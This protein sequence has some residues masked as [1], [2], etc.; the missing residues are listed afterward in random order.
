[1]SLKSDLHLSWCGHKAAKFACQRWHY[2]GTI[3]AG[4]LVKIGV[5]EN[6]R[7]IGVVI[8][9][10]GAIPEIGNPYGLS[11]KSI[12]ELTRVALSE[13]NTPTTRILAIAIK[14]LKASNP[15]LRLIVSY[16]DEDQGHKGIIYQAGNWIKAGH[17]TTY[18]LL[19]NGEKKHGRSLY[20]KYGTASL[21]Y[22]KKHVDRNAKM[23]SGII[24]WRFLMPLDDDMRRQ[25]KN[26]RFVLRDKQAMAAPTAQRRG[27]ADRHAPV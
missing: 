27:S 24:R 26:H 13:H 21:D 11:Q 10:R 2:S 12:C 20:S 25:L 7:F 8:F 19:V 17:A 22:V 23:V 18:F 14:M 15:G 4:K 3:P 1:M 6:R 16:A 9:S 5:W